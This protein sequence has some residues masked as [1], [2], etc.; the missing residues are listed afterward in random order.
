MVN[1]KVRF[2]N[3]TW[4]VAFV[5]QLFI[6]IEVILTGLHAVGIT[7]FVLTD[8]IKGWVLAVINAV[9]GILAMLG[10]VQDPTTSGLKDSDQA[11]TYVKPK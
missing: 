4:V 11:K 9:F 2:K 5:S 3:P 6:L 7:D 10:V 1:W 8:A